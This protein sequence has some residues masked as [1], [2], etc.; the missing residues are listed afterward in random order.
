MNVRPENQE[1]SIRAER[2]GKRNTA[3]VAIAASLAFEH[4]SHD[5]GGAQVLDDVSIRAEPGETLCLLGPSGS[6]KTTLLRIASGIEMQSSGRVRINEKVVSE[7]SVHV[8]PEHRGVGLVFQDYALF[9]HLTILENVRFGLKGVERRLADQTAMRMLARVGMDGHCG[10]YPQQLSGGEQQRV[11]LARALA[12]RPGIL[13]MDEPFSGLDA[14]LR[15][16]VRE[17]TIGLLRDMRATAVIV[18]HDPEEALRVGDQIA[19]L[20]GGRLVQAGNGEALYYRPVDMFTAR[21]FSELNIFTTRVSGGLADTPLGT[22]PAGGFSD[23]EKIDVCVRLADVAVEQPGDLRGSGLPS[24]NARITQ[25][26]FVG[27]AEIVELVLEGHEEPVRARVRAGGLP[28]GIR[29]V[30]ARFAEGAAMFF[31]HS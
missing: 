22:V 6:G 17:E 7:G 9:P 30:R 16:S 23:G 20:R 31:P 19:L 15:D 28:P 25:R 4:V 13:L 1:T 12:P 5:Y 11:A 18:T 3:G 14:R 10:M 24:V 27:I 2:W 8:P 29:D 26:R 21:F